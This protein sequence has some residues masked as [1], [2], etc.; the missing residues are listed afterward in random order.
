MSGSIICPN[1]GSNLRKGST[2]CLKCG[3]R[4]E[5]GMPITPAESETDELPPSELEDLVDATLEEEVL[6]DLEG[7]EEEGAPL[8]KESLSELEDADMEPKPV[9]DEVLHSSEKY[10]RGWEEE[11]VESD[12][13][14]QMDDEPSDQEKE[15]SKEDLAWET[16]H[17]TSSDVKEGMPFIEVT[18]P[19][20][21]DYEEPEVVEV[22]SD[23]DVVSHLFPRGRGETTDDFIDAVVG[24]PKRIGADISPS[25]IETPTCPGCGMAISRDEFEYPDYVYEAMG[26]A[27]LD[28]G[29]EYLKDNEHE[30]GIEQFEIAKKLYEHANNEKM[31]DESTKRIDQGYDEM[32][33]HHY[34]QGETLI[35]EGQFEWGIVQFKKA[36]ELYM[37]STDTKKRVKCSQRVRDSYEEWGKALEDEG[38]KLLKTGDTRAALAMYTQAAEKYREAEAP[39]RLRGLDKKIRAA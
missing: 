23:D 11:T 35:K 13:L 15:Y 8:M 36:R 6:P 21:R 12:E 38:D 9:R 4:I 16:P 2:F 17:A 18:P 20:V 27:R 33:E 31:I 26:R 34:I 24:K 14:E 32:A 10:T 39:K 30:K 19:K 28:Q 1:C 29:T 3:T 22:S 25:I 37:F 7:W 5:G